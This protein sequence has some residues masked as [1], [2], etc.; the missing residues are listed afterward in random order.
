MKRTLPSYGIL[1][2]FFHEMGPL[3]DAIMHFF[4][5]LG[6]LAIAIMHFF[7]KDVQIKSIIK[8]NKEIIYIK[9]KC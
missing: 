2:L 7:L 4:Q 8:R 9:D 1:L 5:E 3:D 6:P